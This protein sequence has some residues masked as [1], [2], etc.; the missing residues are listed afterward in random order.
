[1]NKDSLYNQYQNYIS[2]LLSLTASGSESQNSIA[3]E[4]RNIV[5]E[6][7]NDFLQIS[8]QLQDAKLKITN[9]YKSV[10][11]SCSSNAGLRVPEAQR[12]SHTDLSW[13]ES[14]RIQEQAAKRIQEWFADKTRKAVAEK[15]RQLQLEA[16]RR[17]ANALSAAEAERKRKE[18]A[19]MLEE[20]R[21]AALL[22]EM[23]RKHR[24]NS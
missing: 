16:K 11:E 3:Q 15:Q 21:G 14:I 7:E 6:I 24:K 1:M 5:A 9:Q 8:S 17:A 13:Q 12:P 19:A 23:K 4:E 22:E 20:K 2:D 18:E 10:R